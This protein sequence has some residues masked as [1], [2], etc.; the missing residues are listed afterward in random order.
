MDVPPDLGSAL[1][2]RYT[3]VRE[4]GRGGMATVYVARDLRHNRE[5]ALK[6]LS[7]EL[8]PRLTER[9]T[10]EIEL[11]ARLSHPNIL[12]LLDSGRVGDSAFYVMPLVGASLHSLLERTGPLPIEQA[13]RIAIEVADALDYSHRS[14]VVHRDIKPDN[15][16]LHQERAMVADFGIARVRDESAAQLTATGVS[17]GTPTYMSPEQVSGERVIDGRA[18][19]YALGCVLFEMLTGTPPYAGPSPRAI[20]ARHM[21]E[22]PP[23]ARTLRATIPPALDAIMQRAM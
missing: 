2:D 8:G 7:A 3:L 18:D 19:V 5:I 6:V 20:M 13:V 17:I 21:N 16:L 12:P 22:P 11:T 9:F 14:G 1:A 4:L 15:I 10:R 23:R